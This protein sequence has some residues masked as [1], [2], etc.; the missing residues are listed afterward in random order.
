M[1]SNEADLVLLRRVSSFAWATGG[2]ASYVNTASSEGPSSIVITPDEAI[3]VTNNIEE[4]RLNEEEGLG[5]QGWKFNVSPWERSQEGLNKLLLNKR[6]ISDSAYNG[7]K[8]CSAEISRLRAHLMPTEIDRLRLL[9]NDCARGMENVSHLIQPGMSEFEI[10]SLIGAETQ[11]IGIQPIVNLVAVDERAYCYRHPL[12]TARKLTKYALLVL[13]GRRHGLVCSISRM[14]HFGALPV[15]LKK[16]M[17]A[18]ANINEGLIAESKPGQLLCDTLA[19][20]IKAYSD[21]GY[22]NE[23]KN[24]HQGGVTGFEPREYLALP[25]SADQIYPHQALAWN[26]TVAGAKMEDTI[27]INES[28]NEIIT[29]TPGWPVELISVPGSHSPVACSLALVL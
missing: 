13:S 25:N 28:G 7:A 29:S 10:C 8:D 14:V 9:G 24:H 2:A 18:A 4:M 1:N 20:G 23:W 27:I 15:E 26:P 12:P 11:K 17:L 3:V 5:N 21:N 16:R 22:P 6:V 19:L